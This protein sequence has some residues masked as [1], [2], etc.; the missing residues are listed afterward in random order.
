[1]VNKKCPTLHALSVIGQKWKLSILWYFHEKN[2]EY[3]DLK[4]RILGIIN[5][6]LTKSLRELK[7][8]DSVHHL[9]A[10]SQINSE[11]FNYSSS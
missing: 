4:C 5:I 11:D 2:T 3:N 6:M 1:M 9:D 10:S 7:T 8:A